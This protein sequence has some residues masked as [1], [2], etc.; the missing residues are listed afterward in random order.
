MKKV[1]MKP[2]LAKRQTLAAIAAIVTNDSG[3]TPDV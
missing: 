1:Y 2:V 3:K